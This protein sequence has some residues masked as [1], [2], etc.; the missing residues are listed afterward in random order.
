MSSTDDLEYKIKRLHK[1]TNSDTDEHVLYDAF[2][3]L[4][5]STQNKPSECGR[6]ILQ[7]ALK[8]KTKE[9]VAV[10]VVVLI[11]FA[12]FLCV[13]AAKAVS[14]AHIYK[15]VEK[16]RNVC[17]CSFQVGHQ[18]PYQKIWVA[19]LM[20]FKLVESKEETTLWD[21][22]N[23]TVKEID[24][25]IDYFSETP[26]QPDR[27]QKFE[28]SLRGSFGLVPFSDISVVK[29]DAQWNH[30]DDDSVTTTIPGTEVYDLTWKRFE[31]EY[32]TMYSKWRVF[33]NV[34]TDLPVRIE[35]YRKQIYHKRKSNSDYDYVLENF[36]VVTYPTEAEIMALIKDKFGEVEQQAIES[37]EFNDSEITQINTNIQH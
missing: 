18:E 6:G 9:L 25:S 3:E 11:I 37:E 12:L 27:R 22:N 17:I 15:A 14:L 29:K 32:I 28:D 1:T 10:A 23:W 5:K 33:V 34:K 24:K 35:W 26:I 36:S 7:K 21:L 31:D 8:N 13:P 20:R 4:E 16:V 19:S 2:A 30:V